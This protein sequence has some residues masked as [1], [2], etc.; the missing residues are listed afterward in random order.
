MLLSSYYGQDGV[1]LSANRIED[2]SAFDYATKEERK[3]DGGDELR[4]R[5]DQEAEAGKKSDQMLEKIWAKLS[6]TF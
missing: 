3:Y 6:Q 1:A 2:W 5:N 4:S